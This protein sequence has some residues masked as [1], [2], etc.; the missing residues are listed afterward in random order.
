MRWLHRAKYVSAHREA[1]CAV[2]LLEADQGLRD[3]EIN[4][5]AVGPMAPLSARARK[6]YVEDWNLRPSYNDRPS[7]VGLERKLVCR[8]EAHLHQHLRADDAPEGHT[9][10]TLQLITDK[11]V[12]LEFAGRI[13]LETARQMLKKR[14]QALEEEGVVYPQGCPGPSWRGCRT[15]GFS[16]NRITIRE[17]PVVC[18]GETSRQL[19]GEVR[20]P[21]E[22]DPGRVATATTSSTRRNELIRN[23]FMIWRADGWL[24]DMWR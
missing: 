4:R 13:S 10:W 21:I 20:P 12:E 17:R 14:T 23:R 3:R 11:H 24:A 16:T 8:Q 22:A 5:S 15:C 6:R 19:T 9:H 7:P 18:L 2:V 1:D